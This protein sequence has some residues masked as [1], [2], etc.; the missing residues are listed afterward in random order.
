[1]N[2]VP[3]RSF[4]DWVQSNILPII[5]LLSFTAP[6]SAETV[7]PQP[8]KIASSVQQLVDR[9]ST[10]AQ[11]AE[12]TA[13]V[14]APDLSKASNELLH[15]DKSGRIELLFHALKEVGE[16]EEQDLTKLGAE[17]VVKVVSPG[18]IQ[19]WI[20]H[21]KVD[22]AAALPW[23]AAVTPPGYSEPD[24]GSVETEGVQLH[25][26]DVAQGQS[27]NGNGMRVGV[28][29][30]GV[31]NLAAAQASGDLPATVTNLSTGSG[32]EGTAMLEIVHD[33]APGALLWFHTTGNS[34]ATHIT[35]LNNLVTA[36]VNIITED[37]PFD[38]QPA[39]Q[40][41]AAAN[42]AEQI[43][44]GGIAVHSSAGN[45]AL[46]HAAR[47]PAVGTGQGPDGN[48]GPFTSCGG[49]S[50]TNAVDLNPAAAVVDTT[51]DV[52]LS[53][54]TPAQPAR[55]SFTLQWSEP[56]AIFPTAGAGGFTNLDLY[57]MAADGTTCLGRSTNG[58]G[59]GAG[60]TIEQVSINNTG[61]AR[62]AK[63][64]VN[65][66]GNQGAQAT[67][68]IDL[69]WRGTDTRFPIDAAVRD[70]SLNP[71]SN[72]TGLA[73]SAAAV[74][75]VSGAVEGFSSGGPVYLGLTTVCPG[76][77]PCA[78]ASQAGP[79]VATS[80]GPNWAAA[81]GGLTS[82]A[83]GFGGGTCP[84]VN[85]GDQCRFF[86]TSAAAPHAAACDALARDIFG[87]TAGV[88]AIKTR[89]ASNA[90]DIAPAGTDNVTGAGQLD[91][92]AALEPPV[93]RCQNR[94][95]P[96]DASI[97][98]AS[99]VSVDNGSFDPT[100]GGSVALTQTPPNPYP[101]GSTPV[102]LRATDLDGLFQTCSAQVTVQDKEPPKLSNVP[103]PIQK[104]QTALAGT[105]VT[106]PLP[107]AM[108]N[109]TTPVEVT[110]DAPAVFP[111]GTTTVTFTATDTA[112]NTTQAQT[113]VTIVDTTPPNINSA[114]A[115]P[116]TLWP[117]NHKM[118]PTMVAVSV[119]DICDAAPACEIIQ[120]TSNEPVNG[121]GDGNTAP[122]WKITGK[123]T[124]DLRA[125][126]AGTGSGRVYT[127]TVR[128]TD[129][130]GNSATKNATV[131]V[132]HNR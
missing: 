124:V 82:G 49:F 70:G 94:T 123:L 86:G 100:P 89:L 113:T 111:L 18:M 26:A 10:M 60:D 79:G 88:A 22:E 47:V 93:A 17:I 118:V 1:M 74:N 80:P 129:A 14:A 27:V 78:G 28:I 45:Q 97:C 125:E 38:D 39:F 108:D 33:M 4:M 65:V 116:P 96:T 63:I 114:V 95:V 112:G 122:D 13:R 76:A 127:I 6:L 104:E 21:D 2:H 3:H 99:N 101:L 115:N 52:T 35:A 75:A 121:L 25:R 132:P 56:R 23:V 42:R 102:T 69:R 16:R 46:R 44:T 119:T 109:C 66:A 85:P 37:I 8:S 130:S 53:A 32:D 105:P 103:A 43:A 36:G 110:S 68:R 126:R 77:Y 71:D 48:A 73:T 84:P 83:G 58:Q 131:S 67:P 30:D 81:D 106:V 51:F 128:C 7:I 20:P 98:T 15:V 91:C 12:P 64:V 9:L 11:P 92:F 5:L 24:V 50:P 57:V 90:V 59:N 29:S 34:V 107:T 72:Y 62:V 19:A 54:G 87:A 61:A 117:P 31:A 55:H 40:Q 41:G 120:V